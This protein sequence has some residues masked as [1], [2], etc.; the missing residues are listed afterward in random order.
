[1][2]EQRQRRWFHVGL[3][4]A[5]GVAAVGFFTGTRLSP[6]EHALYPEPEPAAPAEH[7]T[8]PTYGRLRSRHGANRMRHADNLERMAADGP[9]LA[10]VKRPRATRED[11]QA[12][13]TAR[14]ELR[15]Y[16][17]APPRVPHPMS[18]RSGTAECLACHEDGLRLTENLTAPPM[19]HEPLQ[20]CTECHVAEDVRMPFA[21]PGTEDGPPFEDNTFFG[22][23]APTEGERAWPGAPPTIPHR[24]NMRERCGSCHG[25]LAEGVRTSHPWRLACTECHTP[26]AVL[27]QR[28]LAELPPFPKTSEVP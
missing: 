19:S 1:M 6:P 21:S 2:D 13:L 20:S 18:S 22:Q 4:F 14:A 26:S 25:A 12:A 8:A 17:G 28:P 24:T 9:V 15:A 27:D 16:H 11:K 10:D 23:A 5:A 7:P 3:A